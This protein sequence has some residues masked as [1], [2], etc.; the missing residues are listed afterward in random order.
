MIPSSSSVFSALMMGARPPIVGATRMD[1]VSRASTPPK[2]A[3]MLRMAA[4]VS[5][6]RTD[7]ART[8]GFPKR[9]DPGVTVAVT[10][11]GVVEMVDVKR[12]VAIVS[13]VLTELSSS[14]AFAF[15][16]HS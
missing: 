12:G 2:G 5:A 4:V 3:L 8:K 10:A 11:V 14:G 7:E 16:A 1:A 9:I 13:W 6:W 15:A